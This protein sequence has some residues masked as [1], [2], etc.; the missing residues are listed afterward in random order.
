[1]HLVIPPG[2]LIA[3]GEAKLGVPLVVGSALT[4]PHTT[5][6]VDV[7]HAPGRLFIGIHHR[8]QPGLSITD[9]FKIADPLSLSMQVREPVGRAQ[10]LRTL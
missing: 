1:M 5:W 2:V 8:S 4:G 6:M 7:G 9:T 3:E 10:H